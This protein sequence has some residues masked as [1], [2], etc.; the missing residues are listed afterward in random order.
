MKMNSQNY[1]LCVDVGGTRIKAVVLPENPTLDDLRNAPTIVIR[2]LGWL[3]Y[4]I[5]E[6]FR[7]ENWRGLANHFHKKNV[8]YDSI[9]LCLPGPVSEGRFFEREDLLHGPPK[10]PRDL[11]R[12]I[13][14]VADCPVF[15]AKDA[16]AWSMG[17]IRYM[18]LIDDSFVY[19][20]LLYAFGTG[21]GVSA[22][23][24][25]SSIH[26]IEVSKMPLPW[27]GVSE[28]SNKTIQNPWDVHGILGK[29]FFEWV[30]SAHTDWDYEKIRGEYTKRVK[31]ATHD[32]KPYVEKRIGDLRTVVLAGGNAEFVS[33]RALKDTF[34]VRVID[35]TDRHAMINPDL[36]ALLGIASLNHDSTPK[37]L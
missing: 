3:N 19:P 16:D 20:V 10:I 4:S 14:T 34:S 12:A 15:L 22:A 30:G 36:I 6:L 31:A 28:A 33:V 29:E 26:S 18:Q 32:L 1:K 21:F 27:K 8:H 25:P 24:G 11:G 35:L 5:V 17:F 2:T 9:H 37:P 13:Q 7:P 23:T